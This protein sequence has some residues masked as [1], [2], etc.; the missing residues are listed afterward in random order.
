MTSFYTGILHEASQSLEQIHI[1]NSYVFFEL[2][3]LQSV[4]ILQ[5]GFSR[6]R[7]AL[8]FLERVYES[9]DGK[10]NWGRMMA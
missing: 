6:Q 4:H 1:V 7:L 3:V 2:C 5:K 8:Q 9:S 10:K